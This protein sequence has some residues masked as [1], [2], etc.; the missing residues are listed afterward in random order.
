MQPTEDAPVIREEDVEARAIERRAFLGRF[1]AAAGIAG[2]LGF[3]MG[4]ENTD[5]CDSDMRDP[6]M[7]DQDQTDLPSTDSDTGDPCDSDGV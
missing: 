2:V 7:S 1:G 6:P 4:C 3:V 5:S